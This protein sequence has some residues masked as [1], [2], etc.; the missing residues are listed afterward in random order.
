MMTRRTFL[1]LAGGAG[2]LTLVGAGA[3]SA[4]PGEET[5]TGDPRIAYGK[6]PC[7]HCNMIISDDRFAA[8]IRASTTA[9]RHFDDVGCMVVQS[10]KDPPAPGAAYYVRDFAG[11]VW[12]DAPSASYVMSP[13][14]KS[15]MSYDVAA[16]GSPVAA[17]GFAQAR[18]GQAST[19]QGLMADLQERG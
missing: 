5:L 14:I 8:A 19:W 3:Y 7:A 10:R 16:F 4:L 18:A 11:D 2:A 15:P 12:L 1:T 6:E 13:G 9:E 17:S